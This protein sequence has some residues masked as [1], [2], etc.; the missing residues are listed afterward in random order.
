[1]CI[2][3]SFGR[4]EPGSCG[5][6]CAQVVPVRALFGPAEAPSAPTGGRAQDV[7]QPCGGRR[8]GH[9]SL[10]RLRV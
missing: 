1:M 5:A 3:D 8:P 6:P 10:S 7:V 4:R 9:R 2:R